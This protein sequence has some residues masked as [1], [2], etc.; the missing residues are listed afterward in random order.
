MPQSLRGGSGSHSGGGIRLPHLAGA[1]LLL[2]LLAIT[3]P[4]LRLS[5]HDDGERRIVD[6]RRHD[7]AI[8]RRQGTFDVSISSP[9]SSQPTSTKSSTA[10]S[11]TSSSTTSSSTST[12]SSTT[13]SS[14][15]SSS[16]NPTTADPTTTSSSSSSSTSSSS[17]SSSSPSGSSSPSNPGDG[18][19]DGLGNWGLIIGIIAACIFLLFVAGYIFRKWFFPTSKG[20]KER[21]MGGLYSDDDPPYVTPPPTRGDSVHHMRDLTL[22]SSSPNQRS[23]SPLAGQPTLPKIDPNDPNNVID[24]T[25]VYGQHPAQAGYDPNQFAAAAV[26]DPAH[27]PAAG[28]YDPHQYAQTAAYDPNQYAGYAYQQWPHQQQGQ[29]GQYPPGTQYHAGY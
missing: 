15:S 23:G 10:S 1:F 22:A 27:Y 12:S 7:E 26:Y 24:Q 16:A 19:S 6:D 8:V 25:A 4:V 11:S 2:V 3:L 20:F 21:K 14:S 28:S 13:T 9:T 5:A 18:K 17:S 29:T